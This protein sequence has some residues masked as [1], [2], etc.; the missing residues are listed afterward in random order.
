MIIIIGPLILVAVVVA[1]V[2]GVLT[3]GGSGHALT[4][5]SPILL[6]AGRRSARTSGKRPSRPQ[7]PR[8]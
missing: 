4:H 5:P 7:Y 6:P 1:G 2:A 3:N 8:W